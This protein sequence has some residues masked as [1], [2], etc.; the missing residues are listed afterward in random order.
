M[1]SIWEILHILNRCSGRMALAYK[2][3]MS[4]TLDPKVAHTHGVGALILHAAHN[5]AMN[6]NSV[7]NQISITLGLLAYL[8]YI[9]REI[10]S[11]DCKRYELKEREYCS[12]LLK[13]ISTKDPKHR[14]PLHYNEEKRFQHRFLIRNSTKKSRKTLRP[15]GEPHFENQKLKLPLTMG[16]SRR[17]NC[18]RL[19]NES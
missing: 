13:Y 15:E 9:L 7:I 1:Y 18:T 8:Q 16:R 4:L 10:S 11:L 17:R 2:K 5:L 19:P 12:L 14:S 6:N 3:K